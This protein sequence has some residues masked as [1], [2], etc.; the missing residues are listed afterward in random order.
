MG[1][2]VGQGKSCSCGITTM[3]LQLEFHQ[4]EQAEGN[5]RDTASVTSQKKLREHHVVG[6]RSYHTKRRNLG[7]S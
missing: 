5:Y 2:A 1:E 7:F 4:V 3:D 6:L